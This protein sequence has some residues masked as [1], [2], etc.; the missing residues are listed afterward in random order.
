MGF[1]QSIRRPHPNRLKLSGLV[2][3]FALKTSRFYKF[4]RTGNHQTDR[5]GSKPDLFLASL[6]TKKIIE[7]IKNEPCYGHQ[8]NV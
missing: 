8:I 4:N 2:E 5:S 3:F 7:E 1:R 6:A